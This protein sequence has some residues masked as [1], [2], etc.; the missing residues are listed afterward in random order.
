MVTTYLPSNFINNRV[1]LIVT[2]DD[3]ISFLQGIITQDIVSSKSITE[4]SD[5]SNVDELTCVYLAQYSLMLNNNGRYLCDFFII[6]V[7]HSLYID[8]CKEQAEI[9]ISRVNTYKMRAKVFVVKTDLHLLY[10]K[11]NV[12]NAISNNDHYIAFSDPRQFS[13]EYRII[14]SDLNEIDLLHKELIT[15]DDYKLLLVTNTIAESMEIESNSIPAEYNLHE[16]NAISIKKGCYIGQEF[17]N[18]NRVM[19]VISKRLC[20]FKIQTDLDSVDII[21]LTIFDEQMRVVLKCVT[22]I[23]HNHVDN[24]YYFLAIVRLSY[25]AEINLLSA[26]FFTKYSLEKKHADFFKQVSKIEVIDSLFYDK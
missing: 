17:T 24:T 2:G 3:R 14:V 10:T 1:I 21:N 9:F 19:G 15:E 5:S 20:L 7:K 18:R 23:I 26:D 4:N 12:C 6:H 11:K 13:L 22:N 8:I 16:L 25:I